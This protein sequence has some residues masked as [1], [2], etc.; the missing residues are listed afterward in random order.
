MCYLYIQHGP[1]CQL[2]ATFN[3]TLVMLKAVVAVVVVVGKANEH[4]VVNVSI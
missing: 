3:M 1:G 2:K 4:E